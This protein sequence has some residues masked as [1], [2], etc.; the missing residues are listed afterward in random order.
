[1]CLT[2]MAKQKKLSSTDLHVTQ[3]LLFEVLR[4]V[5]SVEG[6]RVEALQV[7]AEVFRRRPA[8]LQGSLVH[9]IHWI[10]GIHR[11]HWMH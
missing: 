3:R 4:V 2:P 8:H 7:L 5:E 1:M 11:I 10:H 9:R 6:G